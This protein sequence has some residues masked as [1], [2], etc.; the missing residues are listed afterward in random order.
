MGFLAK[1]FCCTERVS[2]LTEEPYYVK[3][4]RNDPINQIIAIY[5]KHKFLPTGRQTDIS[6]GCHSRLLCTGT[7]YKYRCKIVRLKESNRGN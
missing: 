4:R 1:A 2:E 7:N 6:G 5:K 3:R